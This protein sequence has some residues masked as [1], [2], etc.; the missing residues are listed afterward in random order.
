MQIFF[1]LCA[2]SIFSSLDLHL[3]RNYLQI[4]RQML[5]NCVADTVLL[6]NKSICFPI[7]CLLSIYSGHIFWAQLFYAY[8]FIIFSH[9]N[10]LDS[11]HENCKWG[12]EFLFLQFLELHFHI[13]KDFILK[14]YIYCDLFLI[15]FVACKSK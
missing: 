9:S 1:W 6:R 3:L 13:V 12:L 5:R 14:A 4:S 2:L 10:K 8:F 11:S 7:V 15:E